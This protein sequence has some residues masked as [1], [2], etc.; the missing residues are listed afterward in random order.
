MITK[1]FD[2]LEKRRTLFFIIAAS[3]ITFCA[4]LN[5]ISN[6]I[7]GPTNIFSNLIYLLL[8]G[9][10]M[11]LIFIG[12]FTKR[13]KFFTFGFILFGG[14][15]LLTGVVGATSL[16]FWANMDARI[17]LFEVFR[18]IL[19]IA[20]IG[21]LVFFVLHYFFN[22]K[23]LFV[24]RLLFF[25]SF[26]AAF[27]YFVM[28]IVYATTAPARLWFFFVTPL[29]FVAAL[30]ILPV[31]ASVFENGLAEPVVEV[32]EEKEE[33]K[34]E[35]APKKKK[36]TKAKKEEVVEEPLDEEEDKEEDK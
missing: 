32:K 21:Y 20:L 34:E 3:C 30:L 11:A 28:A 13:M 31:A 4:F 5:F 29:F 27:V 10:I 36:S 12:Y 15:M 1:L 14:F 9:G 26:C 7:N 23:F 6:A 16:N 24:E 18:F 8:I 33:I 35:E 17:V 25:I 22:R 19:A 2:F